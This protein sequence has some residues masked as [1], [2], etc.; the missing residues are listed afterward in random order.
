[1]NDANDRDFRRNDDDATT[2]EP[3]RGDRLDELLR[4]W[5]EE[6]A[7][8]AR[9]IRDR[10]LARSAEDAV[11]SPRAAG[12]SR[13]SREF[14]GQSG[15]LA[16]IGFRRLASLAAV[17]ALVLTL[18][19]LFVKSSEKSAFATGGIAQVPEGG[20]L[21]ALDE[22]GVPIGPCPLQ[23][24]DVA[25]EISGPFAR[26]VVEQTYANP[27]TRTIEAVYTFPLSERAAVD[28]MTMI[29][30]GP[31]GERVV[32]GEVKERAAARA[33]YEDARESGCSSRSGRTSS[34]SR[35][36]TSS[37]APRSSSASRRSRP[38]V[39]R[40]ASRATSSRWWL[41]RATCPARRRRCRR[42]PTAGPCGRESCCADPRAS[43]RRM[44]PRS[45]PRA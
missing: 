42:C 24:T 18:A 32:E 23:K 15:V 33:I 39:A 36:R 22:D 13:D 4:A 35:W 44:A 43:I 45:A 30:R 5:H 9:A 38:C 10:V 19:T 29:V 40:T 41:G 16:R 21:D 14:R 12:D 11:A 37:R 7:N 34:R 20:A 2:P 1:M 26:T 8:S 27:Y 31:G 28:R 6:N 17:L 25:V 3:V